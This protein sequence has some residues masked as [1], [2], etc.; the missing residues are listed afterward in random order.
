VNAREETE[1]L[2]LEDL[3]VIGEQLLYVPVEDVV[4]ICQL[5]LAESALH[6]PA[7][8]FDGVEFYPDFA[9]KAAVLCSH[10]VKNHPL[11]DGNKRVAFMC[12][13]EFLSRNGCSW[14]PLAD[15][16]DG[17]VTDRIIRTVAAASDIE[18][19]MAGFVEWI[20]SCAGL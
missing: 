13:V 3:L 15:D 10:L 16:W 19:V 7:A 2:G 20:R 8:S 11:P 18:D 14:T 12:M 6:S 9:V 1:Y 4:K 5:G 17:E